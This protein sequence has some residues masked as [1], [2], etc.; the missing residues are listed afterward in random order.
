[1]VAE[2]KYILVEVEAAPDSG[3][4]ESHMPSEYREESTRV[5][6]QNEENNMRE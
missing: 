4:A 2:K 1:M 3:S 6:I 5:A